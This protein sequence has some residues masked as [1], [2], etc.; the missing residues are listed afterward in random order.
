M[1]VQQVAQSCSLTLRFFLAAGAH[2]PGSAAC[3]IS[4]RQG[5]LA[6]AG[7]LLAVRLSMHENPTA[8]KSCRGYMLDGEAQRKW[9]G[10]RERA[11]NL[12]CRD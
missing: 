2:P 11:A 1:P 9:T 3:A 7:V 6:R 4:S 12:L 5:H 10:S 8:Q